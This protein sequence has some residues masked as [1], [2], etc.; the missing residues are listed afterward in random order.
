M[1]PD[2][3]GPGQTGTSSSVPDCPARMCGLDAFVKYYN[4]DRPQLCFE[5]LTPIFRLASMSIT[6]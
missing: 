5:G 3:A 2:R 4:N 1:K 6:L